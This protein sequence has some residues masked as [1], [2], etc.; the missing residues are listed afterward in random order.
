[1]DCQPGE[2]PQTISGGFLYDHR[3][4]TGWYLRSTMRSSIFWLDSFKPFLYPPGLLYQGRHVMLLH[5][6]DRRELAETST[7]VGSCVSAL[8]IGDRMMAAAA[9]PAAAAISLVIIGE[10]FFRDWWAGGR[11]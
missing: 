1:M 5:G 3:Y 8:E 7:L 9:A 2:T 4:G 11:G 6:V 10:P